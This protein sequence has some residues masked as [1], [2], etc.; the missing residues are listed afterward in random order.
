MKSQTAEIHNEIL[1][2]LRMIGSVRD[3]FSDVATLGRRENDGALD[4]PPP[5]EDPSF[6][7][8][9]RGGLLSLEP[10]LSSASM[11]MAGVG[12]WIDTDKAVSSCLISCRES[13]LA[14]IPAVPPLDALLLG[15]LAC[16]PLEVV[17]LLSTSTMTG[18]SELLLPC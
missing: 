12:S 15:P 16:K 9:R 8:C 1:S 14:A 6:P 7:C 10:P 4:G 13:S 17:P 18:I 11:A 2:N 5:T 3:I